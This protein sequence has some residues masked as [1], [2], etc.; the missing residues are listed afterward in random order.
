LNLELNIKPQTENILKNILKDVH[1]QE[2]FAQNIISYQVS[3]LKRG[4]LNIQ[5]DLLQY[6]SK[7]K[8]SSEEFYDMFNQGKADDRD[9]FIIWAG[10]YEMLNKNEKRLNELG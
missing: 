9:D 3:E 6:E 4:I 7:Y 10:L 2:I 5:L 8:M 1:D